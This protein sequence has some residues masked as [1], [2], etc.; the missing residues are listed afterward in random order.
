MNKDFLLLR[1]VDR[2]AIGKSK[3]RECIDCRMVSEL[4]RVLD[5]PEAHRRRRAKPLLRFS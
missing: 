2:R 4:A 3:P 5:K 1:T